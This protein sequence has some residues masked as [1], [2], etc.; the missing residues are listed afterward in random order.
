MGFRIQ[1]TALR[2][3]LGIYYTRCWVAPRRGNKRCVVA[4]APRTVT[5]M[6]DGLPGSWKNT[7]FIGA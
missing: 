1:R 3:F 6:R 7:P 5:T 2:P 4:V